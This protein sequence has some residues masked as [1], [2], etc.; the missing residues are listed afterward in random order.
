[1][2]GVQL[3]QSK[4]ATTRASLFYSQNKKEALVLIWLTSEG[5]KVESTLN[6]SSGVELGTPWSVNLV[7]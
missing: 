6:A 4:A 2:D 3:W 7:P 5:Q 1:M